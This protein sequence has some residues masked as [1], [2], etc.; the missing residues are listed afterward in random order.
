MKIWFHGQHA[1]PSA[2]HLTVKTVGKGVPQLYKIFKFYKTSGAKRS[3]SLYFIK[4][5]HYC[6]SVLFDCTCYESCGD[7]GD[8]HTTPL[9][10]AWSSGPWTLLVSPH[11]HHHDQVHISPHWA[12]HLTWCCGNCQHWLIFF[13]CHT[14]RTPDQTTNHLDH[15]HHHEPRTWLWLSDTSSCL[16]GNTLSPPSSST[17]IQNCPVMMISLIRTTF[18]WSR[19]P[20]QTSDSRTGFFIFFKY[21]FSFNYETVLNS[22]IYTLFAEDSLIKLLVILKKYVSLI[23][24][25]EDLLYFKESV[26]STDVFSLVTSLSVIR[27]SD[28]KLLS[29]AP[30]AHQLTLHCWYMNH[31]DLAFSCVCSRREDN[32]NINRKWRI[33]FSSPREVYHVLNDDSCYLLSLSWSCALKQ[34]ILEQTTAGAGSW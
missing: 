26:L 15:H 25:D 18:F 4:C 16:P 22:L 10:S 21:L 24:S 20:L 29:P 5:C 28:K 11:H 8:C 33:V 9:V 12:G 14:P 6:Y 30:A 3:E 31:L 2:E 7:P 17:L 13:F 27:V 23:I 1:F 34:I 32:T 19:V